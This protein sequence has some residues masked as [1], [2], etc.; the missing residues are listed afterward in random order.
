MKIRVQNRILRRLVIVNFVLA[1]FLCAGQGGCEK[2]SKLSQEKSRQATADSV[3]AVD[4]NAGDIENVTDKNDV[5]PEPNWPRPRFAEHSQKR[6]QMVMHIRRAYGFQDD[7]VLDAMQHIPRHEFVTGSMARLWDTDSPLP[8]GYGQTISQPYIVAF[9]TSL[10]ELDPNDK[11]LEIGTGSGY[12]AA[13]LTELT[14]HVY[15]IEIVE[16]LGRDAKK[17]LARLGYSTV[18]TR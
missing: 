18:K 1:L 2:D 3:A 7:A 9:M 16:P 6:R 4:S 13:V 14:P 11:V 17:R 10:L 5:A 15:T 8:I 12:Q